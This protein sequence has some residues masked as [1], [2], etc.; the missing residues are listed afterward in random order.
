[1]RLSGAGLRRR[2]TKALYPNHRLPPWLTEDA[3]RDRSN[4]L[5]DDNPQSPAS[6]Y[7]TRI[8]RRATRKVGVL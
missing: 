7:G 8:K 1:M 3:T 6:N 5:L 2:R 4:R